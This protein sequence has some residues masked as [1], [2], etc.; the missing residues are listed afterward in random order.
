[1]GYGR[2]LIEKALPMA[3]GGQ[4]SFEIGPDRLD[5]VFTAPLSKLLK[6]FLALEGFVTRTA[7]KREEVL[8]EFRSPPVPDL[9]LLDVM[10][11]D[12]DGFEIL[13]AMQRH[14]VL[15]TVPVIMLTAKATRESVQRGIVGGADG[16]ITKPFEVDVL[17]AA[18]KVVLGMP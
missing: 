16:Y 2:Y 10:L 6:T 12:A 17:M 15:K 13:A 14:P 4:A 11:P 7:M 18:V 3:L 5:Y 8:N 9:V 1:M